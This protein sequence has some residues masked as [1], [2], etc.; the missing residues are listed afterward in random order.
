MNSFFNFIKFK[1][2]LL[3]FIARMVGGAYTPFA[4]IKED[5]KNFKNKE[6]ILELNKNIMIKPWLI[7][8]F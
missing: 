6:Y 1:T 7:H 5:S 3:E 4:F 8:K 2:C